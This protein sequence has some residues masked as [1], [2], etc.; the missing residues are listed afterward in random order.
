MITGPFKRFACVVPISA[1]NSNSSC[2]IDRVFVCVWWARNS[3]DNR[4]IIF[5]ALV[6][7]QGE[8]QELKVQIDQL[9]ARSTEVGGS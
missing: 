5:G 2:N 7:L 1:E 6:G 9:G 4:G 3:F 8:S